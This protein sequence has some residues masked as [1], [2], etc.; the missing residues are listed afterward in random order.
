MK[1]YLVLHVNYPSI[2][3]PSR[4]PLLV[5]SIPKQI[6]KS[7]L[8]IMTNLAIFGSILKALYKVLVYSLN[9]AANPALKR[10]LVS[11]II[12]IKHFNDYVITLETLHATIRRLRV[13]KI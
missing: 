2:V 1:L 5:S 6:A 12:Y 4:S 9:P 11:T 7:Q 13:S 8:K 10:N 3:F